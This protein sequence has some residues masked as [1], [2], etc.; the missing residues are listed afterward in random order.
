MKQLNFYPIYETILREF[1]KT[2]TLRIGNREG[3]AAGEIV[4]LTVGWDHEHAR[5]LRTV[6]IE[7]VYSK[8]IGELLPEDLEGES[9]D[10]ATAEAAA[11]VVG[12]VYKTVL[13]SMDAVTVIKFKHLN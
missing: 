2:V 11:M 5:T 1:R 12:C 10:C 8:K 13:S 7:A 6:K 4:S 9:P 3:L